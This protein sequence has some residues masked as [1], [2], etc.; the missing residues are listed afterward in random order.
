MFSFDEMRQIIA[1]HMADSANQKRALDTA[2]MAACK[3]AYERG[4]EDGRWV[5]VAP[6]PDIFDQLIKT[7]DVPYDGKLFTGEVGV[8]D[9]GITFVKG[10]D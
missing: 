3:V 1:S 8:L 7:P 10:K 9:C 6:E 4:L 5:V 2:I